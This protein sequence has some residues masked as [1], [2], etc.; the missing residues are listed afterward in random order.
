M[1]LGIAPVTGFD[2]YSVY[3]GGIIVH[4]FIPAIRKEGEVD[5]TERC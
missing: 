3:S 5:T 1:D 2:K 4:I